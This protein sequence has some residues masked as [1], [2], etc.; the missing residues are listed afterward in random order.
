MSESAHPAPV[1]Q[2]DTCTTCGL[3]PTCALADAAI[4]VVARDYRGQVTRLC[5]A[6]GGGDDSD[7]EATSK[8]RSK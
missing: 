4:L 7:F 8:E 3:R 6:C 2:P 5:K 1:T